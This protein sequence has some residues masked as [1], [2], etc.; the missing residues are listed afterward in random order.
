MQKVNKHPKFDNNFDIRRQSEHFEYEMNRTKVSS[1]KMVIKSLL[2][3]C[4]KLNDC[5]KVSKYEKNLPLFLCLLSNFKTSQKE[6][7]IDSILND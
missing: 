3:T 6:H 4:E 5:E 2:E 1:I 7:A